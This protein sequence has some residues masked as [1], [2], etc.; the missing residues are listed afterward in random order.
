[1]LV[2]TDTLA[3]AALCDRLAS[4]EFVTVDTEFMRE[5]TY[6]P[7]L[8]L[9]QL[10][11]PDDAA[12]IDAQ[13]PGIDLTPLFRLMSDPK[14]LKVFHAARQDIEIFHHLTGA[15]PTPLFDTQVAAMVCGFG[16]SVG[17]ET[18]AAKLARARIDKSLRFTDWS[19]RPLSEKQLHYALADVTHLRVAYEKLAHRLTETGRIDWV[20]E[21]MAVLSSPTTYVTEPENA[22][23]RLRLRSA[24]PRFLAVVREIAAWREREAKG[25]DLPRNRVLRDE[26]LLD[27][28]AQAPSNEEELART[29]SVSRSGIAGWMKDGILAAV[30]VA[31]AIPEAD[32]PHLP[33]RRDLPRG[34][35]PV[36]DLL[37]VLLKMKSEAEDVASRLIAS[38]DDLDAIAA[39]DA[40]TVPA[41]SG[42]RFEVFGEDALR[43][44]R[45]ELALAVKGREVRLVETAV[46]HG[47]G[48]EVVRA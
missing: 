44:K 17:Y 45:G 22:W 9:V 6:W 41:L 26:I 37:K 13:A 5:R 3:L 12:V 43:L 42:W 20:A 47:R 18:L 1:M 48:A 21:E 11:G 38:S 27:I 16:E 2:V 15:I 36:V 32:L 39:D 35:G 24:N 33:E 4:A 40:A 23:Q 10:A 25:R 28:A 14:V 19:R 30:A 7:I 29:R 34:L 46:G 31:K 8:C